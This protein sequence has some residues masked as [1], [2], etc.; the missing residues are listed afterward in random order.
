MSVAEEPLQMPALLTEA[1]GS[2][3]TVRE[4]EAEAEQP[5][6]SVTVTMSIVVE[7]LLH[8]APTKN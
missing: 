3:L 5:F 4:R 2:G 8:F 1:V 6:A 7:A